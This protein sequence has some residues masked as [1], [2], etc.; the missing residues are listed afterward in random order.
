MKARLDTEAEAV[1]ILF[2]FQC[3]MSGSVGQGV[4]N[5]PVAYPLHTHQSGRTSMKGEPPNS[6]I[7]ST[8]R[9]GSKEEDTS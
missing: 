8:P 9:N 2:I 1:I 7:S 6:L 3:I 5:D 4:R